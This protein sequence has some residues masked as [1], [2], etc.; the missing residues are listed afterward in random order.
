[1]R[2]SRKVFLRGYQKQNLWIVS[3]SM[4]VGKYV[5]GQV[6]VD[7]CRLAVP[8]PRTTPHCACSTAS[9]DYTHKERATNVNTTIICVQCYQWCVSLYTCIYIDF[10]F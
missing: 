4:S 5:Q 9:R 6:P 7:L 8:Q 3:G 10:Y 1:M 2:A